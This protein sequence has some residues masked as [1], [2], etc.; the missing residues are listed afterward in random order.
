MSTATVVANVEFFSKNVKELKELCEEHNVMLPKGIVKKDTIRKLL[1]GLADED[2]LPTEPK[3]EVV[4][5]TDLPKEEVVKMSMEKIVKECK[6][7]GIELPVAYY[8]LTKQQVVD[9]IKTEKDNQ[10]NLIKEIMDKRNKDFAEEYSHKDFTEMNVFKKMK[11]NDIIFLLKVNGVKVPL[12]YDWNKD[13]LL[14][15]LSKKLSLK[16]ATDKVKKDSKLVKPRPARK[17]KAVE[18][19]DETSEKYLKK[20]SSKW[21]KEK[22]D[23][24][25]L[26]SKTKKKAE[27][28]AML[29]KYYQEEQEETTEEEQVVEEEVEEETTEEEEVVEEETTEEEEVVEEEV[30]EEVVEEEETTEEEQVVEGKVYTR[31]ELKKMRKVQLSELMDTLEISKGGKI[32]GKPKMIELVL[33]KQNGEEQDE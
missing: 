21:L 22:R 1:L 3:K 25:G 6:T 24:F 5:F 31:D 4:Q 29:V 13:L 9:F 17:P 23:Q 26:D 2:E 11:V 27:L 20:Q 19:V 12:K 28:V 30:K 14:K 7:A 33:A 32:M 18:E 8:G 10:G 15:V 16:D